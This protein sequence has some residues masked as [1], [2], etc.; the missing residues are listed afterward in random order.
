MINR[1]QDIL[2]I[3]SQNI[4]HRKVISVGSKSKD[5]GKLL[6]LFWMKRAAEGPRTASLAYGAG[7]RQKSL[8]YICFKKKITVGNTW[9]T[10][11]CDTFVLRCV[12]N[13]K[14]LF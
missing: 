12:N 4:D 11:K 5:D 7:G 10:S 2:D 6:V 3:H 14:V 8:R 13:E 1:L 9:L